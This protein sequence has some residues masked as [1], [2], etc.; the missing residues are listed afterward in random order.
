M[1]VELKWVY[2]MGIRPVCGEIPSSRSQYV[3]MLGGHKSDLL[4][5]GSSSLVRIRSGCVCGCVWRCKDTHIN[6]IEPRNELAVG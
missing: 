3:N 1:R 4:P 5:R 6:H 2:R